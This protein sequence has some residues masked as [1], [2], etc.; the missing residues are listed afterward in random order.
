M[1]RL[2]VFVRNGHPRRAAARRFRGADGAGVVEALGEGVT[3][4]APGDRVLIQP[5]LYCGAASSAAPGEQSLCVT[6]RILGEHV[7]GTFAELVVVP[8]R[9][10]LRDARRALRSSRRRRF[11]SPYQTAWRILV[12]RAPRSGPGKRSSSTASAAASPERSRSRSRGS[13]GRARDRHDVVGARSARR[14]R[15]T[16]ADA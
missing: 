13:A 12:G 16:G 7:P 15:E 10:R 6:F 8:G 5:G 9:E 2:D 4:P 14:A 11:R 1:N 3:G